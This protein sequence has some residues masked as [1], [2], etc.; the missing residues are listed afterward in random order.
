MKKPNIKEEKEGAEE[1]REMARKNPRYKVA[2]KSME[3]DEDKH[4]K[5]L[6]GMKGAKNEAIKKL[7]NGQ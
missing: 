6:K 7:K 3:T 1:Y 5:M 4:A 2:L